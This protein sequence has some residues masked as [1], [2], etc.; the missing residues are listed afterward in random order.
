MKYVIT[1]R[2]QMKI[3]T[4]EIISNFSSSMRDPGKVSFQVLTI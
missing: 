1:R 2:I 3:I 4:M